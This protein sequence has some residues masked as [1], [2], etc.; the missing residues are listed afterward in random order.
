[1][2]DLVNRTMYLQP[3]FGEDFLLRESAG[4]YTKARQADN[5]GH[6]Q[7]ALA[8]CGKPSHSLPHT[9]RHAGPSRAAGANRTAPSILPSTTASAGPYFGLDQPH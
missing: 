1:V 3:L 2:I 6:S 8:H 4:P 7:P 9:G 5:S